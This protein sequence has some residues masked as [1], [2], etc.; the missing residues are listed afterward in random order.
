M[1]MLQGERS[2]KVEEVEEKENT[3]VLVTSVDY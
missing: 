1:H 3:R 2:L